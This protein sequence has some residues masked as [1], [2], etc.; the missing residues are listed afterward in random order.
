MK[1]QKQD[2]EGEN[3]ANW[4]LE[5]TA[6]EAETRTTPGCQIHTV[7]PSPLLLSV[8]RE[9]GKKNQRPFQLGG[10]MCL[11]TSSHTFIARVTSQNSC[12][13]PR[14]ATH[15]CDSSSSCVSTVT[16]P[17]FE[18]SPLAQCS[19]LARLLGGSPRVSEPDASWDLVSSVESG[20]S[21]TISLLLMKAW[22]SLSVS[23]GGEAEWIQV[24]DLCEVAAVWGWGGS[25]AQVVWMQ[26]EHLCSRTWARSGS[27]SRLPA[28]SG[29]PVCLSPSEAAWPQPAGGTV[30]LHLRNA[31]LNR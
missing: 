6:E 24:W 9:G 28:A 11:T 25:P 30:S 27:S 8:D 18:A 3:I 17:S 22:S 19:N 14:H 21:W 26:P 31:S 20:E 2:S 29:P 16:V 12:R 4:L 13:T 5:H 15:T 23:C 7:P 1:D 10:T